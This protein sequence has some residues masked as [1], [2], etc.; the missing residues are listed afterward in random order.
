MVEEA[1]IAIL[2]HGINAE[3]IINCNINYDGCI[4]FNNNNHFIRL[5]HSKT[6]CVLYTYKY[7]RISRSIKTLCKQ[8]DVLFSKIFQHITTL[9]VIVSGSSP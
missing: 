9:Y 5:K 8:Y 4:N 6:P 1:T 2:H 7:D 3:L